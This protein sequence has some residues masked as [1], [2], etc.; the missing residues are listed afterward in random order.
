ME[1]VKESLEEMGLVVSM[2]SYESNL[3]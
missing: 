2:D 3:Y 1:T